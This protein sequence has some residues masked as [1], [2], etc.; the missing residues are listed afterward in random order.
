MIG[1]QLQ[2]GNASLSLTCT[3]QGRRVLTSNQKYGFNH[4]FLSLTWGEISMSFKRTHW[5]CSPFRLMLNS[6]RHFSKLSK[7]VFFVNVRL[8]NWTLNYCWEFC[9]SIISEETFLIFKKLSFRVSLSS[10]QMLSQAIITQLL[11]ILLFSDSL[12]LMTYFLLHHESIFCL[13]K[14]A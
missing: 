9:A 12:I 1:R 11:S 8:K 14:T 10:A 13:T 6:C 2:E 3:T 5:L 4:L 7:L